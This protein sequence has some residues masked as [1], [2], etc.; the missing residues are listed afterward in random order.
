MVEES[1]K[2]E[3]VTYPLFTRYATYKNRWFALFFISLGLAIVVIDNTVLN[4][5]IPYILRDLH[6]SFT[7]VQWA[8]SGYSLTI[9]TILIPIGRVGDIFGRKK[10]FLTFSKREIPML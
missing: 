3:T 6:S 10:I 4:V 5:S 7:D 9:A 1:E 8:I 2:N